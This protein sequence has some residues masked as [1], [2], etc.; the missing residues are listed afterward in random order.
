MKAVTMVQKEIMFDQEADCCSSAH[1]ELKLQRD[2]G[3]IGPDD[4]FYVLVTE[5]WAFDSIEEIVD[6][7]RKAGCREKRIET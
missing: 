1:Q 4:E 7:L 3:G 6:L 5:R 2:N